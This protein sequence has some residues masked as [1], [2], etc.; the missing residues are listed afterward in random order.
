M[1]FGVQICA[2]W[3]ISFI[4]EHIENLYN[5]DI[6]FPN[7]P[8][9]SYDWLRHPS[10]HDAVYKPQHS[11]LEDKELI[12]ISN[13]C[14][15]KLQYLEITLESFSIH[16]EKAPKHSPQGQKNTHAILNLIFL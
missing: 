5:I 12:S 8:A 11:I 4:N 9:E 13:Y 15:T 3:R 14:T 16:T 10:V 6:Y 2:K 1:K 7:I